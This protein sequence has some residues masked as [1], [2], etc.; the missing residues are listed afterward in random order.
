LDLSDLDAGIDAAGDIEASGRDVC[1]RELELAAE[2]D[3][4]LV[5]S[6]ELE[7]VS[8]G[9]LEPGSADLGLPNTAVSDSSSWRM[10]KAQA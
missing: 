5:G 3:A 6:S 2:D 9:G 4:N 10:E 1:A 8:D 7:V